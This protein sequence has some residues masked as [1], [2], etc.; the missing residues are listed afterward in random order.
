MTFKCSK[1]ITYIFC[2]RKEPVLGSCRIC[3]SLLGREGL[4]SDDEE[5][6]FRV[7]LLQCLRNVGAVDVWHKMCLEMAC[8]W[9]QSFGDHQRPEVR[10]TDANVDDVSDGLPRISKP[11]SRAHLFGESSHVVEYCT[12]TWH[13]LERKQVF[14]IKTQ[15][16]IS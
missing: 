1:R 15:L 10:S 7:Q 12:Y 6:C 4:G 3:D 13:N 2:M 8:I 11:F 16:S 9:L 14:Q 5:R